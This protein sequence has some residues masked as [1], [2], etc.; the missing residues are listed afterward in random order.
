M[1]QSAGDSRKRAER[2]LPAFA[3]RRLD[4]HYI[5]HVQHL[6]GGDH[7]LHGATP[8]ADALLLMSNDYLDLLSVQSL[9][10]EQARCLSECSQELLMSAVF[11]YEDSAHQDFE[12]R[13][14]QFMSAE[15][16]VLCQSGWAAN[17]G[18][19]QTL[20]DAEVPVYLDMAA[21]ASLWEGAQSA[22]AKAVRFAHNNAA[23]ARTQINRH[24]PGIIAVD[25]V[26][27]T[28]GSTAPL[29]TFAQ[30]AEETGCILIVDESH[31][32][33]THGPAGAGMVCE[34]GL[35]ERVHFRTASLAKTF[36]GRAGFVSCSTEF[37]GFFRVKSRSAIFRSGLLAHEIAWFDAAL[38][39]IASADNRHERLHKIARHVRNELTTIGYNVSDGTEQIIAL[40]AGSEPQTMRLRDA[41]QRRGIFGAVFC[42]PAT[43]KNRSLVRLTLNASHTDSD[44]VCLVA[45]CA[46]M[47]GEVD[48]ACW[49]S[50]RRQRHSPN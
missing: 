30:L 49:S 43:A 2:C 42:H 28:D 34:M 17:V 32:L 7:L 8:S 3:Q 5:D 39:F 13:L 9:R 1:T 16:G 15:D 50:T 33:G 48:L 26:Y 47:R 22:G 20:A 24:G 25:A 40:E 44:I 36:A 18:L 37:K 38:T 14:A 19:I 29:T 46:D 23:H 11:L 6:W 27:S 41:L 4:S 10:R 21:H 35:A 12:R 31:S 45:A